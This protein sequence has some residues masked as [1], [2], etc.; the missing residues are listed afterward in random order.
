MPQDL[1]FFCEASEGKARW[2][3]TTPTNSGERKLI[4][5]IEPCNLFNLAVY[6]MPILNDIIT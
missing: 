3:G 4:R 1:G 2:A 5:S 6:Q